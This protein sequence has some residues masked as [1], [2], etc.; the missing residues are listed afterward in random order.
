[1]NHPTPLPIAPLSPEAFTALVN[2][3]QRP[4][5]GFLYG[6]VQQREQAH[7]L[8]QDTFSDAWRAARQQKPPF[9][10]DTRPEE[11]KAWL[12]QVAYH[13]AIS[14]L[15]RRRLLFFESFEARAVSQPDYADPAS[16]FDGDLAEREHMHAAL[17]TLAPADAACLL[18]RVVQGLNAAEAGAILGVSPEAVHKRLFLA[19]QR[20]RSAYLAQAERPQAATRQ[21]EVR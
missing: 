13:R 10:E 17:A 4:L 20:L 2:Q 7:D 9:T 14:T 18:L 8:T 19:K 15:R 6:L 11:V 12:F 3:Y 1:M 16:S 5:F 21:K